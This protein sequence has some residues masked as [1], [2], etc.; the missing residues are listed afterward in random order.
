M[1]E[2]PEEISASSPSSSCEKQEDNY[3]GGRRG[4]WGLPAHSTTVA[5][6][7]WVTLG[8]GQPSRENLQRRDAP[9][10]GALPQAVPPSYRKLPNTHLS[11]PCLR[12]ATSAPSLPA[13]TPSAGFTAS[14]VS[15][16]TTHTA[17]TSQPH[18]AAAT[19]NNLI[20]FMSRQNLT[21]QLRRFLEDGSVTTSRSHLTTLWLQSSPDEAQSCT[22]CSKSGG[23]TGFSYPSDFHKARQ[24][25]GL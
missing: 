11:L 25:V 14:R 16:A 18:T 17:H 12:A 9:L 19:C 2:G 10:F 21:K 20:G 24:S 8:F 7:R 3:K 15:Q 6:T 23:I 5:N 1:I 13:G 22:T 4:L